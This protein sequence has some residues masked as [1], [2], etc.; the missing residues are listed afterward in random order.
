MSNT[1]EELALFEA[2]AN[3]RSKHSVALL[4][5]GTV[6]IAKLGSDGMP[7]DVL[8]P[9]PDVVAAAKWVAFIDQRKSWELGWAGHG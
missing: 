5:N 7:L 6:S 4:D 9:F 2:V 1:P 8:P 3:M